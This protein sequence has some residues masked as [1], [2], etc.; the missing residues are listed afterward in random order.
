MLPVSGASQ[1]KH[2]APQGDLAR[3]KRK[4]III[5]S[6][7]SNNNKRNEHSSADSTVP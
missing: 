6:S 3:H 7:S 5:I 2:M 4:V 1:L